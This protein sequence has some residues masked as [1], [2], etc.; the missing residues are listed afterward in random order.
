MYVCE[1]QSLNYVRYFKI[2][3]RF[4]PI[5]TKHFDITNS[6]LNTAI[7]FLLSI[8]WQQNGTKKGEKIFSGKTQ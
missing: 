5:G 7:I 2:H 1:W 6:Q 8:F 3:N 4:S